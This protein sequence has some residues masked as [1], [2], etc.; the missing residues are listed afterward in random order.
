MFVCA[1]AFVRVRDALSNF[2]PSEN[3]PS[4]APPPRTVASKVAGPPV[5]LREKSRDDNASCEASSTIGQSFAEPPLLMGVCSI[6]RRSISRIS[7]EHSIANTCRPKPINT[8][9]QSELEERRRR[10][11][12][13]KHKERGLANHN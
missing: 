11:K 7:P 2:C 4:R 5:S 12:A 8:T 6:I 9:R 10:G 13:F 1:C 3:S